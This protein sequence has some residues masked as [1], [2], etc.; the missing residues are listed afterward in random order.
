MAR[1][2]R[3]ISTS[4]HQTRKS[5]SRS[6]RRTTTV[7]ERTWGLCWR[8]RFLSSINQSSGLDWRTGK[9][10]HRVKLPMLFWHE[11]LWGKI[12]AQNHKESGKSGTDLRSNDVVLVTSTNIDSLISL[13]NVLN[14]NGVYFEYAL[15]FNYCMQ[16][17]W[18]VTSKSFL[19]HTEIILMKEKTL[20]MSRYLFWWV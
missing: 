17:R 9:P 7:W 19:R 3:R 11:G 16:Q 10:S 2:L 20:L 13:S 14:G 1:Q 4:S 18:R 8:E 15:I 6:W 5:T 12:L